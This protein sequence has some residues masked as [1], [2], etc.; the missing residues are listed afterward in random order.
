[1]KLKLTGMV[2]A[3]LALFGG[4]ILFAQ[5]NTQEGGTKLSRDEALKVVRTIG[6]L[7]A[8]MQA[9]SGSFQSFE[10]LYQHRAFRNKG[11]VT[12]IDHY[13][14]ALKNY[15]L[16]VVATAD[17]KQFRVSLK[18][19]QGCGASFFED[20]SFIIYEGNALGCDEKAR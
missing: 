6:T 17:G 13:S 10:Q 11:D 18:P 19:A 3:G 1:M 4:S 8:T 15:R 14:G 9:E 16:S 12:I 5:S 20:E 2:L 7:E